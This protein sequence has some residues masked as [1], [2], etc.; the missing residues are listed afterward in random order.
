MLHKNTKV[1]KSHIL[2][3]GVEKLLREYYANKHKYLKK[4]YNTHALLLIQNSN[5][6]N[7]K[8]QKIL[9]CLKQG[10]IQ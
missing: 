4:I 7:D 8:K 1:K 3:I 10:G 2:R 6:P 5:I 9:H